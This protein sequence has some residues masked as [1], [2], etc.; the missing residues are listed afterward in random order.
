MAGII[1]KLILDENRSRER[2][3]R[4]YGAVTAQQVMTYLTDI[5]HTD[6]PMT[7][8]DAHELTARLA[9]ESYDTQ[10]QFFDVLLREHEVTSR[11]GRET[12]R[13][14]TN[15]LTYL[16]Q[17]REQVRTVFDNYHGRRTL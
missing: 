4:T 8:K 3:E 16:G 9:T 7:R 14:I 5:R 11:L 13:E 12:L 17:S 2:V 1:H 6:N 15:P 10:T